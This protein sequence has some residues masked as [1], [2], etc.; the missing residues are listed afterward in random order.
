MRNVGERSR[1]IF[2]PR[3]AEIKQ[4]VNE[5]FFAVMVAGTNK[6]PARRHGHGHPLSV[7][8][9]QCIEKFSTRLHAVGESNVRIDGGV[10]HA[11]V[12]ASHSF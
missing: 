3:W 7:L 2:A 6:R 1:V 9:H 8:S 12:I 4:L 5:V 11:D 10:N